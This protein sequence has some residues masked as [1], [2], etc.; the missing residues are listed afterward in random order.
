MGLTDKQIE[1]YPAPDFVA[2]V[3]PIHLTGQISGSVTG[4]AQFSVSEDWHVTKVEA[5]REASGTITAHTIDVLDDAVSIL[6]A[7]LD[8][9]AAGDGVLASESFATPKKIA[10]GSVV[11]VNLVLTGGAPTADNQTITIH[12]R[13]KVG[14]E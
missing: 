1:T 7:P 5:V 2:K 13:T 8:V 3:Y 9:D 10:S 12:Y 6:T 4:V 14:A 11:T